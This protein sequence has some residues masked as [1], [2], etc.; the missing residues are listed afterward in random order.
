MSE[1]V[2]EIY[3]L[4]AAAQAGLTLDDQSLTAIVANTRILQTLHA[5]FGAIDLP[6][7]LDPAAVLRL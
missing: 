7:D 2:V 6:D 1:D 5:E 3:V 4:A